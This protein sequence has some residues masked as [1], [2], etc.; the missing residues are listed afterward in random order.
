MAPSSGELGW[1]DNSAKLGKPGNTV[2][3]GHSSGYGETFRDLEKLKSGDIV[4]VLAGG[5]RYSYVVA[6]T[7][8]LKERWESIETRIENARWINPSRDERLTLISCWP[9][10]VIRTGLWW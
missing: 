9:I 2:I 7:M 3:N 8:I 1:H 10:Q 6:N 4:Q 5:F